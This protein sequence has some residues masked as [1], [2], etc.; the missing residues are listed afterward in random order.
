MF[1]KVVYSAKAAY[2]I[3]KLERYIA[4]RSSAAIASAYIERLQVRCEKIALAP[5]Q[6]TRHDEYRTGVRTLGFERRL[7]I[8]FRI[9]N[10]TVLILAIA[11]AGR[12]IQ[13]NL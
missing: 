5:L 6:G 8:A 4:K 13:T 3:E 2:Q 11:Y 7:S 10:S 1:F 12:R 9:K